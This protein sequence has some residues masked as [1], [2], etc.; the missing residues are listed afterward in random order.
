M[1]RLF[2]ALNARP[3]AVATLALALLVAPLAATRAPAASAQVNVEEVYQSAVGKLQSGDYQGAI[4]DFSR[5]IGS[6]GE[7]AQA[8]IGRASAEAYAGNLNQA[9]QDLN[10]AVQLDPNLAE[11][12][13][14][15]GVLRAQMGDAAG[16]VSDLEYAAALFVSRGD[17]GNA[18]Q[19]R[20][21]AATLRQ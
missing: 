12:Y 5:V 2:V 20:N 18:Q 15:R 13:Y 4:T 14:N 17:D 7:V 10:Q 8:Y 1:H 9:L 21:A 19:A 16:A 6:G 11:A 3:M